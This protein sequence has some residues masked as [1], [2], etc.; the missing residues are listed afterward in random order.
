M[1]WAERGGVEGAIGLR[2][3]SNRLAASEASRAVKDGRSA[4]ERGPSSSYYL[5]SYDYK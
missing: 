1:G 5:C 3:R 2:E 4:A